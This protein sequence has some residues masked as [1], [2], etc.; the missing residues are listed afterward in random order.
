MIIG[1]DARF[2][3]P[4]GKGL[5]RYTQE[6][7]DRVINL[8]KSSN[9][10]L[11]FVIFLS[12]ENFADF[13]IIDNNIKKVELSFRWYSLAEQIKFP[14]YIK[15]YKIDLMHFPHFNIPIFCPSKFIVTIHD[16]ILTHFPTLRA[17]TKHSLVY[18]FKNLAY[19]LVLF[20]AVKLSS[21]ILT[22]SQFTKKDILSLFKI[23]ADKIIVSYEGVANL[24]DK[25]SFSLDRKQPSFITKIDLTKKFLLYVGSAYPHKNL[26]KLVAAFKILE[27]EN[28]DLNLLLVGKEDFFYNRLKQE[29]GVS[30][31]I[32]FSGYVSDADLDIL[33]TK[34]LAFI[35][36]SLYEGFGLP[37]LEA[38]SKACP[39]LSSNYSCLPEILGNNVLYFNPTDVN[40]IITKTKMIVEDENLRKKLISLG[41]KLIN[42]YSWND[43]AKITL[44]TYFNVLKK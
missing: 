18:Y 44:E 32:I 27:K 43:C 12:K 28:S 19:R 16:L 29:V 33:Y 5:G 24:T 25:K 14:F 4:L 8:N 31:N 36:P 2:Y 23:K 35:F 26:E 30:R 42:K 34:A 39:V 20:L 40:D 1:I 22:V 6:V 13:N 15:K 41:S 3:G 37:P 10:D 17:T 11:S 38:M 21:K 7:V 9:N